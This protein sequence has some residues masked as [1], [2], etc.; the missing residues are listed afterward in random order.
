MGREERCVCCGAVIPEGTHICIKCMNRDIKC[1]NGYIR[2]ADN[3][4]RNGKK[5][6]PWKTVSAWLVVA[7]AVIAAVVAVGLI[8]GLAMWPVII[9]YWATLTV[10]NVVDWMGG[11]NSGEK[12]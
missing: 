11:K 1:M 4:E 8:A 6:V 2:C 3:P 7:L 9:L 10:K 12:R 5:P